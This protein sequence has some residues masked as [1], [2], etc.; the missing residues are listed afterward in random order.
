M[1]QFHAQLCHSILLIHML[2]MLNGAYILPIYILCFT[3][4]H[5]RTMKTQSETNFILKVSALHRPDMI[6]FKQV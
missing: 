6:Q 2:N 5:T 3:Y 4:L 1:L